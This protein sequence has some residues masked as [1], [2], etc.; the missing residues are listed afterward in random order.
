MMSHCDPITIYNF[1]LA[2]KST[3]LIINDVHLWA[4]FSNEP[5]TLLWNEIEDTKSALFPLKKNLLGQKIVIPKA[6][7]VIETIYDKIQDK[8]AV[9]FP[10]VERILS[11]LKDYDNSNNLYELLTSSPMGLY[12]FFHKEQTWKGNCQ[13]KLKYRNINNK[14]TCSKPVESFSIYCKSCS[15]NF[16]KPSTGKSKSILPLLEY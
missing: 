7:I 2:C 4:Y 13:R 14:A 8:T 10:V 3:S 15:E 9:I 12:F 1:S 16:R 6:R 5:F 11:E